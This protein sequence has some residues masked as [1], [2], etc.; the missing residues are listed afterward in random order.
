MIRES[1]GDICE[2]NRNAKHNK[3]IKNKKRRNAKLD[4]LAECHEFSAS[5]R[6]V[7]VT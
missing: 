2:M 1:D 6:S 3:K 5:K 4:Q 7:V